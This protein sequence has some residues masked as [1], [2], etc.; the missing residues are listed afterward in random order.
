MYVCMCLH[1][2]VAQMLAGAPLYNPE[3]PDFTC[4]CTDAVL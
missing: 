2:G 3:V 1:L 4:T